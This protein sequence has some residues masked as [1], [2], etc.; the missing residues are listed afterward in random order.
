MTQSFTWDI[1]YLLIY[2]LVFY[3]WF[4]LW[5]MIQSLI[6]DSVF[7][8]WS[9]HCDTWSFYK[10]IIQ[11]LIHSMICDIAWV[12]TINCLFFPVFSQVSS[13][14]HRSAC[15]GQRNIIWQELLQ[16]EHRSHTVTSCIGRRDSDQ[17]FTVAPESLRSSHT[18]VWEQFWWA[19]C[20]SEGKTRFHSIGP[21][22]W[23]RKSG[24]CRDLRLNSADWPITW[25]SDQNR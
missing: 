16:V 21:P 9:I 11:S 2:D 19:G 12:D 18:L 14:C 7:H 6:H 25:C 8:L 15:M 5:F 22:S 23:Q 13:H 4:S 3:H 20:V 10:I 24:L 1:I 17:S